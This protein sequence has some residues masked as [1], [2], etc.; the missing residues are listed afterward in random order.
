MFRA[1]HRHPQMQG[2]RYSHD[3]HLHHE[4]KE[5]QIPLLCLHPG[6]EARLSPLPKQVCSGPAS[7]ECVIE[8]LKAY[9]TNKTQDMTICKNEVEALLSPVWDTLFPEEKRRILKQIVKEVDCDV[10]AQRLGITFHDTEERKEFDAGISRSRFKKQWKKEDEI[11]EE[12]KLR[13][14]LILAHQLRRLMDLGTIKGVQGC[15]PVA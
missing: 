4:E 5:I 1:S 2:L 11:K 8:R 7:R 9:L 14:T 10:D 12:P 3:P 15:L 13:R 6:P